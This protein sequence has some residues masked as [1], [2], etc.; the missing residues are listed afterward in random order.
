MQIVWEDR[1]EKGGNNKRHK[2]AGMEEKQACRNRCKV[3][4]ILNIISLNILVFL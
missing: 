3:L 1:E 4:N 2:G